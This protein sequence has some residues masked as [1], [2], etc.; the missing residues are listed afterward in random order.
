MV[1][2]GF[3][4][5]G[6]PADR[7]RCEGKMNIRAM[8]LIGGA[9]LAL[10]S[11]A[12][13]DEPGWY[14]GLGG[15]YDHLN[16]IHIHNNATGG[17]FWVPQN[18]KAILLGS[19]GYKFDAGVRAELELGYDWHSSSHVATVTS[20]GESNAAALVNLVYDWKLGDY[21]ALSLGGGAGVSDTNAYWRCGG[22]KCLGGTTTALAWQGI[23]GLSYALADDVDLFADYRYRSTLANH[24]FVSF[25]GGPHTDHVG[26]LN[27]HV[28][29]LGLR[30][31]LT[32]P[33]PPPPPA[34]PPGPPPP[35]PPPPVK[36]FI[37]FFDFDKSNLTA[38]GQSVVSEAVKAA[39]Q[40]GFVKVLVTGHTDT[41]GS[42]AY[43]QA[44]S[45]RRAESV[46]GEM[47]R[48]GM[49]NSSISIEGKS[50]HDPLVATGPGVREPQNRRAVIDLGN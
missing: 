34:P 18:D 40:S 44:L 2:P 7:Q 42:D 4:A 25:S 19:F 13:A 22:T 9:L 41:V 17:N 36:T 15:G 45:V 29:L 33:S 24:N 47:V 35:P 5:G 10:A 14:L 28:A 39:K 27:E 12:R 43:N 11:P 38:E 37:V 49:E 32:Q 46:K 16:Q 30:W 8:A 31:Y 26:E 48:Q 3:P 1:A 23:A 20:G 50:F 6:G 21:W